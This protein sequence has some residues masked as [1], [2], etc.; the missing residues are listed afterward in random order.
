MEIN[1]QIVER[2]GYYEVNGIRFTNKVEALIYAKTTK[3]QPQ[4]NFSKDVFDKVPWELAPTESLLEIYKQRALQLR[5]K[6]DYLVLNYSGGADSQ[7][8]LD[9]FLDNNIKLDEIIVRW[10]VTGSKGL[11]VPSAVSKAT[12]YHSEWDLAAKPDI[13]RLSQTHPEIKIEF[14][15]YTD[16]SFSLYSDN[17]PWYNTLNGA[18]F[19]PSHIARYDTG[20][21]RYQQ[22]FVEKGIRGCQIFGT[23]KPRIMYDSSTRS[24]YTYFLDIIAGTV[25]HLRNYNEEYNPTELFYWTPDMPKIVHKQAH[26][27]MDFFKKVPN[28]LPVIMKENMLNYTMRNTIETIIRSLVYPTWDHS[29]FQAPKPTS[30][31]YCEYDDWF[32]KMSKANG[33]DERPLRMWEYALEH[34]IKNIDTEWFNFDELG[35]PDGFKGMISPMYKIGEL[36]TSIVT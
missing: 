12:N 36:D 6:Y 15:D 24:F 18:Q 16:D 10:A 14:Y 4:W 26:V 19:G 9:A 27:V 33:S 30:V 31:F 8:V 13:Q 35:N 21:N 2:L 34:A 3:A 28:L 17:D 7:N 32:V 5:E 11:Y 25:R 1:N 22:M 29:K 20:I 23:D